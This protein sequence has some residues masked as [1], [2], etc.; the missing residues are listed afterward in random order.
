[1]VRTSRV[2]DHCRFSL[3]CSTVWYEVSTSRTGTSK[4]DYLFS[5]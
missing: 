3:C 4:W 1:M 5:M 2:V